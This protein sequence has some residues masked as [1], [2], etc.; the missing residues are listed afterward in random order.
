MEG[1]TKSLFI[2]YLRN[3]QFTSCIR[4]FIRFKELHLF[5]NKLIEQFNYSF[6]SL[7]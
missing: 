2:L 4:D 7:I 5:E 1:L 6:I 3:E